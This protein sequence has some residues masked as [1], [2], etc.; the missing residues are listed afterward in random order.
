MKTERELNLTEGINLLHADVT[1]QGRSPVKTACSYKGV[2][3]PSKA[4][5][6]GAC[7]MDPPD[8]LPSLEYCCAAQGQLAV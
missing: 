6:P 7:M 1:Q 8:L 2:S 3:A 5:S 4:S